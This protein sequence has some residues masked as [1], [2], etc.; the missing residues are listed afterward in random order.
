MNKREQIKIMP[1]DSLNFYV[2]TCACPKQ[3]H[4]KI[5]TYNSNLIHEFNYFY[6]YECK[7]KYFDNDIKHVMMDRYIK[8]E[9]ITRSSLCTK[10]DFETLNW[11][12][13]ESNYGNLIIG[14]G[15]WEKVNFYEIKNLP[16]KV[17]A[18]KLRGDLYEVTPK[19]KGE[20]TLWITWDL[21]ETLYNREGV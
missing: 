4:V 13:K 9:R 5:E 17:M 20:D 21:F 6:T 19:K 2:V 14:Y 18:S 3:H 1:E 10:R 16:N 8:Y 15:K 12:K 7:P 11:L